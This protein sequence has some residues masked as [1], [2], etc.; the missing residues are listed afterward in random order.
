[1]VLLCDLALVGDWMR[2]DGV[3]GGVL[4]RVVFHFLRDA[5]YVLHMAFLFQNLKLTKTSGT[6]DF[7]FKFGQV[8]KWYLFIFQ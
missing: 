4:S 2:K 8:T 1:M 3:E 5:E 7:G 6:A